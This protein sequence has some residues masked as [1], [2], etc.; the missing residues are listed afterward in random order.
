MGGSSPASALL[1]LPPAASLGV[2][3]LLGGGSLGVPAHRQ[4]LRPLSR[5]RSEAARP[6][7]APGPPL[8]SPAPLQPLCP[9]SRPRQGA[10]RPWRQGRGWSPCRKRR[11]EVAAPGPA[12][13]SPGSLGGRKPGFPLDAEP[14][15]AVVER[16]PHRR[17]RGRPAEWPPP[18]GLALAPGTFWI[19]P[20]LFFLT[21]KELSQHGC[22]TT[23]LA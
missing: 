20:A 18:R 12:T 2:W 5:A 4:L 14:A 9:G 3:A 21:E 16:R 13:R 8:T 23:S 22:V 11:E 15:V 7:A 6:T 10:G 1:L 19:F 17:A